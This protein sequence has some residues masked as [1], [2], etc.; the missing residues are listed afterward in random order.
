[1]LHFSYIPG[2]MPVPLLLIH[3]FLEDSNAWSRLSPMLQQSGYGIITMDLPGFGLSADIEADNL[4][5][6]ANEVY[7]NLA[8]QNIEKVH[9]VGHSMGGYTALAFAERFVNKLASITLL[10]ST[11]VADSDEKKQNRKRQID[12][13]RKKGVPMLADVIIPGLFKPDGDE[14]LKHEFVE[15][16][17]H[18]HEDGVINAL[19]AMHDRPDRTELF[20]NLPIPTQIIGG[21]HD[22]LISPQSLYD[23][24]AHSRWC[25]IEMLENSGHMGMAEEPEKLA[26]IM[27]AFYKIAEVAHKG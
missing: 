22:T 17:R 6:F 7:L 12:V 3:G 16:A 10:H 2:N 1:M 9:I 27:D 25:N 18:C 15:N 26:E 11:S 13:V 24:A 19:L 23:L 14:A 21:R 8:F 4:E 5:A 20:K